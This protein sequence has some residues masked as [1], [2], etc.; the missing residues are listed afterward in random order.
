VHPRAAAANEERLQDRKAHPREEQEPMN[1]RDPRAVELSTSNGQE[2][3][4]TEAGN[5]GYGCRDA[6]EDVEQRLPIGF[7]N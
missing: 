3:S 6:H 5:G 7:P 1:M 2:V 4:G